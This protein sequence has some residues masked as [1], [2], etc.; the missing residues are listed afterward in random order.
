[1][2]SLSGTWVHPADGDNYPTELRMKV[3]ESSALGITTWQ[4]ETDHGERF[5]VSVWQYVFGAGSHRLLFAVRHK[6]GTWGPTRAMAD[7][8]SIGSG[9]LEQAREVMREFFTAGGY[10]KV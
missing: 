1:M 6:D 10:S 5:G 7:R 8:W 2:S 3:T 9:R 4:T